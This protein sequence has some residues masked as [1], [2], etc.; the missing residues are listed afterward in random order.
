MEKKFIK[1]QSE[2][3]QAS[4]ID[5]PGKTEVDKGLRDITESFENSNLKFHNEKLQKQDQASKETKDPENLRNASVQ[6][7]SMTNK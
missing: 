2:D 1:R 4:R 5:S 7:F 6:T 3:A